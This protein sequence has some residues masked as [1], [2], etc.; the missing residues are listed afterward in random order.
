[1]PKRRAAVNLPLSLLGKSFRLLSSRHSFIS[2]SSVARR[3]WSRNRRVHFCDL[4]T[5][6]RLP[7]GADCPVLSAAWSSRAAL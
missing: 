6:S 7:R 1:M 2:A 5:Q 4:Y 3:L